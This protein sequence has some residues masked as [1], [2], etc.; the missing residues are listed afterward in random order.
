M[1]K[2]YKITN[3]INNKIYIGYTSKTLEER[4]KNHCKKTSGCIYISRAIQKYGKNNFTIELLEESD[5]KDYIIN[6][7]ETYWI[8]YFHSND[9]DIGYNIGLGGIGGDNISN[10]SNKNE[11]LQQIS[12]SMKSLYEKEPLRKELIRERMKHFKHTEETK[13]KLSLAHKG[14]KKSEETKEKLSL[15]AKERFKNKENHPMYGK[16]HTE[17]TKEKMKNSWNYDKIQTLESREKRRIA[18]TGKK[19]SK[20]NEESK[21]KARH[22][23]SEKGKENIRKELLRRKENAPEL[24]CPYCHKISKD[25]LNMKRWH[26]ENCKHKKD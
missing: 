18:M 9:K 20:W 5:N 14:E 12:K 4:F 3:I 8:N 25:Y 11:I 2:I 17:E 13:E 16:T 24:E 10:N 26:F 6:E 19:I 23:K 15:I 7:R 1:F 22:P 21:I